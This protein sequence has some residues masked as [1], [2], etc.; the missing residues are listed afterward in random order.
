MVWKEKERSRIRAVQMDN[1]RALL[2]IR[3]KKRVL[4]ERIRELCGI[5]EGVVE[6]INEIFFLRFDHTEK[7]GEW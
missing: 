6:R 7:N 3:R 5:M 4:N 2:G 1:L